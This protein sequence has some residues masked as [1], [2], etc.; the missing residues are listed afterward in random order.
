[1]GWNF[2]DSRNKTIENKKVK[3][4]FSLKSFYEDNLFHFDIFDR[5]QN[6]EYFVDEKIFNDL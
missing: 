3:I 6:Q 4:V 5:F 1:M 2:L